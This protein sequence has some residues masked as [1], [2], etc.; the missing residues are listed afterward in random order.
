M[1]KTIIA[2]RTHFVD[3]FLLQTAKN[4]AAGGCYDVIFAVDETVEEIDVGEFSKVSL[5]AAL[6]QELGL[7][8]VDSRTLYFRGDYIFYAVAHC[9]PQVGHVWVFEY[10]VLLNF[11]DQQ[12]P[13]VYLD[14]RDNSDLLGVYVREAE[15]DW[16]WKRSME[17]AYRQVYRCFFPVVRLSRRAIDHLLARRLAHCSSEASRNI[18]HHTS[19]ND[20]AFV[21]TTLINDGFTY[22]NI[23]DI[24]PFYDETTFGF[25]LLFNY[26]TMPDNDNKFYHSVKRGIRFAEAYRRTTC[27]VDADRLLAAD[28]ELT[29]ENLGLS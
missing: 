19:P 20:E 3:N 10:D 29:R 4:I 14:E 18:D 22:S 16:F 11:S 25:N 23:S 15:A 24:A 5:T 17:V 7:A 1:Q 13:F 28:P 2:I 27:S 6:F 21:A 8:G 26:N 12:L 9:F